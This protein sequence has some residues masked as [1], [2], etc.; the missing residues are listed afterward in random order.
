LYSVVGGKITTYRNLGEKAVDAVF[1]KLGRRAPRSTTAENPLP[2]AHGEDLAHEALVLGARYSLGESTVSRLL[3]IY[4]R[5][6]INVLNLCSED[7]RWRRE[8]SSRVGAIGAE[9]VF[10]FRTEMARTLADVLLRRTMVGMRPDLGLGAGRGA[11]EIAAQSLG[12]SRDRAEH[13]IMEYVR[14]IE[15]FKP[16]R[17]GAIR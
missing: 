11:A 15:R 10:A 9:V 12:W 3:R 16:Q 2:G 5:R 7:P 1:R 8:F 6:A 13:E 14:C 17:M 4:G